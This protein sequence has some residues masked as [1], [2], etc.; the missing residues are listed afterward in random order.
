MMMVPSGTTSLTPGVLLSACASA[1]G[2]VAATALRSERAVIFVAPTCFS[3]A[4]SGACMDVAVACRADRW[5]ELAGKLASWSSNTTTIASCLPDELALTW[6][7]LSV[8]KPGPGLAWAVEAAAKPTPVMAVRPSAAM[9]NS[10]ATLRGVKDILLP[11]VSG[12]L[13]GLRIQRV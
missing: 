4:T 1:A 13:Q 9:P 8:E 6:L 2:M 10:E 12:P 3:W 11:P 7:G 5:A